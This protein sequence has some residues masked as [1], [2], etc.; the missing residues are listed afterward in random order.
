MVINLILLRIICF[1][2]LIYYDDI[3]LQNLILDADGSFLATGSTIPKLFFQLHRW[4]DIPSSQV[5]KNL[6]K[7]ASDSLN[8]DETTMLKKVCHV[9]RLDFFTFIIAPILF[10]V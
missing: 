5:A 2:L 6:I 9:F 7:I 10:T 8:E 1:L 4:W 3:L